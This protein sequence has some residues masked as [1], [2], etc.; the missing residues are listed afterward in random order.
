M[1]MLVVTGKLLLAIASGGFGASLGFAV[2]Q[3]LERRERLREASDE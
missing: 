2:K 3:W 1:T